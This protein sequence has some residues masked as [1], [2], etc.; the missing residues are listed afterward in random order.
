MSELMISG[1]PQKYQKYL[2]QADEKGRKDKKTDSREA[3]AAEEAYCETKT[4]CEDFQV[5]L[6]DHGLGTRAFYEKITRLIDAV[7]DERG[8]CTEAK[9]QLIRIGKPT[10]P[11]LIKGL[12][13]AGTNFGK[14]MIIEALGEIKDP[15]AA[16]EIIPFLQNRDY[17]ISA[18]AEKALSQIK[19]P[20]AIPALIEIALKEK[21]SPLVTN[22]VL[23]VL[24]RFDSLPATVAPLLFLALDETNTCHEAIKLIKIMKKDRTTTPLLLNA[25]KASSQRWGSWRKE[26]LLE[27]LGETKDP[28]AV[29]PLLETLKSPLFS[30]EHEAP[31]A[32]ITALKKTADRSV[33]PILLAALNDSDLKTRQA[34]FEGLAEIEDRS[35]LPLFVKA[36]L[37]PDDKISETAEKYLIGAK[38]TSIALALIRYHIDNSRAKKQNNSLIDHRASAVS[39]ILTAIGKPIVPLLIK[40]ARGQNSQAVSTIRDILA[41]IGDPAAAVFLASTIGSSDRIER[42]SIIESLRKMAD[43]PSASAASLAAIDRILERYEITPP[44]VAAIRNTHERGYDSSTEKFIVTLKFDKIPPNAKTARVVLHGYKQGGT[45]ISHGK[46]TVSVWLTSYNKITSGYV[47]FFDQNGKPAGYTSDELKIISPDR[48]VF[49]INSKPL[50]ITIGE[51]P[52]QS[53]VYFSYQET[54]QG[55]KL[56]RASSSENSPSWRQEI[57]VSDTYLYI[58]YRGG[59]GTTSQSTD[60]KQYL[61]TINLL[62][63]DIERLVLPNLKKADDMNP[64]L[65]IRNY[66]ENLRFK[67]EKAPN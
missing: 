7:K 20:A 63:D 67:A 50:D 24:E 15:R 4:E 16:Q 37:D 56:I 51:N 61:E 29:G 23:D 28:S 46:I 65:D 13:T 35:L 43:S 47:D 66:L 17:D 44:E 41:E 59:V 54:S 10:V 12:K 60:K 64:F 11:Y 55:I 6:Y 39:K 14:K 8:N 32:L 49:S 19:D 30:A 2:L 3:A 22:R 5:F 57:E 53:S 38:D 34:A 58:T 31:T 36:L 62:I 21:D 25:L 26:A 52:L 27:A 48:A 1:A 33:E 40:S 9:K 42:L 45:A 18:A